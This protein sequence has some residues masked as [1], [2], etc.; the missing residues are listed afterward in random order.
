MGFAQL[1]RMV[2]KRIRRNSRRRKAVRVQGIPDGISHDTLTELCLQH[3][4]GSLERASY[5]HVSG[6]KRAGAYRLFLVNSKGR[7]WRLIYK[8]AIYELDHIP[9]LKNFP[10]T[11][12]PPEFLVYSHANG[13][14]AKYLPNVYLC[15]EAIPGKHYQYLLEDL[16][17][18]YTQICYTNNRKVKFRVAAEFAAFHNAMKVWLP[19]INKK[20]LLQYNDKFSQ[21]LRAHAGVVFA[22]LAEQTSSDVVHEV[23][24]Q[25]PKISELL[26]DGDSQ[27]FERD[28]P[29][30]TDRV[31]S[32]DDCRHV[33]MTKARRPTV[34]VCKV[35]MSNE[36]ARS[37]DGTC[38]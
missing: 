28:V 19:E 27:H 23:C 4:G 8:N 5:I 13:A 21:M 20:H 2:T 37:L 38:Y 11:P 34:A 10:I 9:A 31:Q 18:N 7:E 32:I 22:K 17:D 16:G 30:V 33:K 1:S 29:V 24:D 25:W 3:T 15:K 35:D 36:L 14:L 6:W 12:G 26:L